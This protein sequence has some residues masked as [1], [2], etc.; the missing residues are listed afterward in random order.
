MTPAAKEFVI[1]VAQDIVVGGAT[2]ALQPNQVKAC[3]LLLAAE[4]T[5]VRHVGIVPNPAYTRDHQQ[6][7]Q[8]VPVVGLL[9]LTTLAYTSRYV[10]EEA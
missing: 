8:P 6:T 5:M 4:S 1:L 7:A 10:Y 3:C 9:W 2:L